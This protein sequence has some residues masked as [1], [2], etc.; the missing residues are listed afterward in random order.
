MFVILLGPPGAGKGTQANTLAQRMKV[1]HISTGDILRQEV[2]AGTPLGKEVDSYMNRGILV[3]DEVMIGIIRSRI[4]KGDGGFFEGFPRTKPQ[5]EAFDGMLSSIGYSIT[6]VIYIDVPREE[7]MRRIASRV[8]CTNCQRSY[9][10]IEPPAQESTC[11]SCGNL[12][13][14]R[15]DDRPETVKIRLDVYEKQTAPLLGYYLKRDILTKID[16]I[17]APDSITEKIMDVLQE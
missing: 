16:G 4:Y 13:V 8:I 2:S 7:L 10:M 6:R 15:E 12:I 1:A 11:D 5:A 17:G 3:P 14:I 9:S